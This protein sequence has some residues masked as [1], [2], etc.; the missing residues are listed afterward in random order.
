MSVSI[1]PSAVV[2][3][4]AKLGEGCS[5]GAY[6][7]IGEH[8]TIG[9]GT[10]I[11]EHVIIRPHTEIGKNVRIFPQAVI[12]EEP[13]HFRYAGEPTSVRIGE[14][15]VLREQVTIHRGTEFGGGVTTV[16]DDC[17]VMATTHI[18]HDCRVG[19]KVLM[20]N[21]I[22]LAGHVEVG[23]FVTMGGQVGMPPF[24]RVGRYAYIA[25]SSTPRKDVPPFLTGKGNDFA[26]QGINIVGLERNGF[27][28]DRIACIKALYRI[29]YRR[30]GL[31]V[32]Q[33]IE[34]ALQELGNGPD[35]SEF[36][37]FVQTSKVGIIR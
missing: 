19:N 36:V 27:S 18:A 15:T 37:R 29:F 35:V 23:D 14:R 2:H 6:S 9:E 10:E 22:L 1:H 28:A 12:G 25:G 34:T 13:Q 8:V 20:A 4:D 31:T 33:A 24:S 11:K 26:M 21:A 5:V 7:V 30:P 17:Y 16:G 32:A 3:P